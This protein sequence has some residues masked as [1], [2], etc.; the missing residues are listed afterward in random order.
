MAARAFLA[1]SVTQP[2]YAS[3]ARQGS[4]GHPSC[5]NTGINDTKARLQDRGVQWLL[6]D[7]IVLALTVLSVLWAI[8]TKALGLAALPLQ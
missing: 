3:S 1:S 4:N 6:A 7:T 8:I 2:L 5:I